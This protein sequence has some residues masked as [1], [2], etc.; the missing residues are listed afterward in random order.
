VDLGAEFIQG[1]ISALFRLAEEASL[2]VVELNGARWQSREGH[3]A[4]LDRQFPRM[5]DIMSRMVDVGMDDDQSFDQ[6]VSS[7]FAATLFAEARGLARLWI[8]SYE[9]ADPA[10]I[11]V[12]SLVREGNAERQIEGRRTFRLVTGYDG[13]PHALQAQ[14][15]P[16]LGQVHLECIVTDVHWR[17]GAVSV[18]ARDP[19][20]TPL[21]PFNARRIVIALP[22]GVL[23]Q[24]STES[25]GVRFSPRLW[26]KEDALRGLEM[27]HV[28]K[29]ILAFKERFWSS[30]FPEEL[31]FL[32]TPD[33]PFPGWWTGYPVYAPVLVAWAGGPAADRLAGLTA[34]QRV[35]RALESLTRVLRTSRATVDRQVVTWGMHDWGMD[36]FARGAYSYVRVGG[37]EAQ[38]TLAT[39]VED[40]LFLAGE[41][42]E[43]AGH[44]A[45]VHG[46]LFAGERA[47]DE[48]LHSL[49]LF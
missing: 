47:A 17:P 29:L 38:A 5:E 1:R 28:V 34:E 30:A 26:Q 31:G 25:G 27:G 22:L 45:T 6:F 2:P 19:L 10:A 21:G 20:A 23:R 35:D 41:A 46:A 48:V 15:T 42:T 9:A 40:T 3:L 4:P 11:S 7:R 8:E 39:P 36:P 18:E 43:L 32:V 37:M 44:Q 24:P 16:E 33:E 12:R 14:L 13:I 49:R